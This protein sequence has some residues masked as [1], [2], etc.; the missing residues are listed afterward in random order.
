MAHDPITAL[1]RLDPF[2]TF[3]YVILGFVAILSSLAMFII[4]IAKKE[5]RKQPGD[6]IAMIAFA[7]F[8]LSLHWFISAIRTEYL[9]GDYEEDSFF[10][11]FNSFIAVNAASF[12]ITY[13]LCLVTYVFF[14]VRTALRN[15]YMPQKTFHVFCWVVTIAQCIYNRNIMYKRNPYGTCSVKVD[16]KNLMKGG[17]IVLIPMIYSLA[18]YYYTLRKLPKYGGPEV[19]KFRQNFMNYYKSFIQATVFCW[20]LIFLSF[21]AQIMSASH[22]I[23][24]KYLFYLG[25]M[26]NTVKILNPI[27]IFFIRL[28]DPAIKKVFYS[29]YSGLADD[30]TKNITL[31]KLMKNF[32]KNI[33]SSPDPIDQ[34]F[35]LN[36]ST[37]LIET[38]ST[39][40]DERLV[41]DLPIGTSSNED[42][43]VN[44]INILPGKIKSSF[45]RSFVA[46]IQ[47]CYSQ[48]LS[49][50]DKQLSE[51]GGHKQAFKVELC[52]EDLMKHNKIEQPIFD[53]AVTIYFPGI[54]NSIL[55]ESIT[56]DTF[57]QAF[58]LADNEE[59]IKK[60]GESGG[61]ASGELFMFTHDHKF[62]IKTITYEEYKVFKKMIQAYGEYFRSQKDSLIG[63][64]YGLFSFN[65][66]LGEQ[67]VKLVVMENLFCINNAAVLRK[68]DMKGSR[69]SRQVLASYEGLEKTTK[70]KGVLKDIDFEEIDKSL[71]LTQANPGDGSGSRFQGREKLIKRAENDVNFFRSQKIIDYSIIVAVVERTSCDTGIL[72]EQ[73]IHNGHH[74]MESSDEKYI[75]IL[76]IID[77]FQLYTFS[78]SAERFLKRT[79]KC[80]PS[81]E[82]SAQ[83]PLRYG[84][85]FLHFLQKITR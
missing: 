63:K 9:A 73:L 39:T 75:Y 60:A 41:A 25:R 30:I 22:S 66:K 10:C 82:T 56:P 38:S 33:E 34:E 11:K 64:I 17:A 44:W 77:Y 29:Y 16:D 36:L 58:N 20:A 78:K 47:T 74:W 21:V 32:N 83:P 42:E 57:K 51:T 2:D 54:F 13:N 4:H 84:E 65:F 6:L 12:E 55:P 71:F 18:I 37:S 61:G 67:P 1:N 52:G 85:R 69:H 7:E 5:L 8:W 53:C 49:K 70:I 23:G 15:S 40:S 80:N 72:S 79:Q 45:T 28:E 31:D 48:I 19:I 26:G 24:E 59:N 76:G 14:S 3:S 27:I 50:Q 81:L 68:Y 46:C 62:I 35:K 43:D